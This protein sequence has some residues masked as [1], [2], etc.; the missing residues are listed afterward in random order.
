MV[1]PVLDAVAQ[2]VDHA[3]LRDLA[4]QP[5][6]ELPPGRAVVGEIEGFGNFRLR[7]VQKALS[8]ARSTQYSR[9]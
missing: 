2:H 1:R 3:A 4:L 6:E 8:W 9:S 7:G 5:G